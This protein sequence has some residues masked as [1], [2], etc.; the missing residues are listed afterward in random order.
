MNSNLTG[1][2]FL[3][4]FSS[5]LATLLNQ[6]MQR[7]FGATADHPV[8]GAVTRAD[9]GV[10]FCFVVFVL[11]VNGLAAAFVRRKLKLAAA[12]PDGKTMQHHV[13]N[14][15]GKPL[16]VLIWIYGIYFAATPLLIKLKPDEGLN[17]VRGFFD[18]VFDLGVFAVLFWLFFRFT[19]VLEARLVAWAAKTESKLDDL[20]VP[21]LGKSLRII[22]P[23]VGIIFA[24]PILNLP[25]EYAGVLAKGSSILLIVAAAIILFQSVSIGEKV[26]LTKFDITAADNLQARKVYTQIHV[27]S[28]V[29][30]TIIG[31]FTVASIWCCSTKCGAWARASSPRRAWSA[32]SSSWRR[33]RPCPICSR[34]FKSP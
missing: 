30:Y 18:R 3:D 1:K 2:D 26:M 19:H 22:V 28:K 4:G 25:T 9:L 15:L 17:L 34:G 13:F 20:F 23:V 11:V 7:L 14:A 32:L 5:A 16:Y 12:D 31:L 29:V 33:R 24:L 10:V 21:L 6:W 27:I 8:F